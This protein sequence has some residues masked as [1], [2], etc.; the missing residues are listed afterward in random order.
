MI[1]RTASYPPLS[2]RQQTVLDLVVKTPGMSYSHIGEKLGVRES[3]IKSDIATIE[4]RMGPVFYED[5]N[6]VYPLEADI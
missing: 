5:H 1:N 4:V 6:K 3:I 2:E